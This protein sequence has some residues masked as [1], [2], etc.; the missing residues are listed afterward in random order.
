MLRD[1]RLLG[2]AAVIA[3]GAVVAALGD[4]T[5][6]LP[7]L[8]APVAV[9][10]ALGRPAWSAALGLYAII[11][12]TLALQFRHGRFEPKVALEILVATAAASVL[13]TAVAAWQHRVQREQGRF[14]AAVD[15]AGIAMAFGPAD[16]DTM[17]H[18][19][20]A[21]CEFFEAPREQIRGRRWQ[22]FT[23][24]DDLAE[25]EAQWRALGRG[26]IQ[27]YTLT[28]RYRL[29]NGSEKWGVL[30]V[31][32]L[33]SVGDEPPWAIEQIVDVTAEVRAQ[34]RL[35]HMVDFDEITGLHSRDWITAAVRGELQAAP[36]RGARVG[37]LFIDLSDYV[38]VNRALGYLAGDA[39]LRELAAD[40]EAVLPT[41][42]HIGRFTGMSFVAVLP[43]TNAADL[44]A[45]AERV[46]AVA[47]RERSLGELRFAR[48]GSIGMALSE[49]GLTAAELLRDADLALVQAKA[50][51]GSRA[52]LWDR[53][54]ARGGVDHLQ[55][56]H[57]LR[58]ALA[59]RQFVVHYQPQVRL[60]DRRVM[61][62]EA[63][64]RWQHPTRGLVG[65]DEFIPVLE[66]SDL[67]LELGRQVVELVCSRIAA[68]PAMPPVSV[69]VSAQEFIDEGWL[70]GFLDII[71]RHEVT[72]ER[73]IVELTETATLQLTPAAQQ[74]LEGLRARGFGLHLDDFGTGYASIS[75][76]D[77]VPLTALKLDRSFVRSL[78]S[79]GDSAELVRGIGGLA[80]GMRLEAIAE[81]IETEEQAQFLLESGWTYG[82]GY[83]FG[84]PAPSTLDSH[85]LP[86]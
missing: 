56:E 68:D 37:V 53:A 41:L 31:A 17:H 81:G 67:I 79:G 7:L 71:D 48:T 80:K 44:R 11:A 43:D 4:G 69:N 9:S 33:D 70:I 77:R 3:I 59:E 35:Q 60:S 30:T 62:Y 63:L 34:E 57:E 10:A 8:A 24:P 22:E 18:F 47:R 19:N 46:L 38:V 36:A 5:V 27:R 61:G 2:L 14:R 73:L 83:L 40:I 21:M 50:D 1:L 25:D 32:R 85:G 84:R 66:A 6:F 13:A 86:H 82:Q 72:P 42:H 55:R 78:G 76:L 39:M 23:H 65:P 75:V 20:D 29:D 58:V 74:A 51:G 28:K 52:H 26:E 12:S 49:P 16:V 64:V 15:S 45:A 54:A